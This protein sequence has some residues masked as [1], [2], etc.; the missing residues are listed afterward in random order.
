MFRWVNLKRNTLLKRSEYL[1]LAFAL[2]LAVCVYLKY[3][4]S[5][6]GG[7]HG[8]DVDVDVDVDVSVSVE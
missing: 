2:L 7:H 5:F 8:V 3:L 4:I 1:K 6:T